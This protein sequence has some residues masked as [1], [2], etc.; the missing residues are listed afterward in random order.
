MCGI[1]GII[2][3]NKRLDATFRKETVAQM[4][5]AIVH[6]GPD[7][8]GFFNN[9]KTSLAMRRLSIIDLHSGD[10]PLWN[11]DKSVLVF[12]N[13]EIYNYLDLKKDLLAKGHRFY[14]NSD[15]ETL[16]HLYEEYGNN[17]SSHLKG[18]FAFCLYDLK[19]DQLLISR[20]RFGEK[21]LYYHWKDQVLSFSSEVASLLENK[22][23]PRLLN[24]EV[25][26]Y[27]LG[28]AFIPEPLTL[29]K[30]VKTLEPGHHMIVSKDKLTIAP[31]FSIDYSQN[32]NRI[33]NTNEAVEYIE[34]FLRQAVSRQSIS[35]VPLGAFLS[36][37]IDSSTVCTLLQEQSSKPIDTFTVKFEEASYDE[38]HIAREVAQRIGS[39]HHE[40]TIP[41]QEFT[42]DIFWEII[43]HVGLP[44]PDSSAIPVYL[45]S[46]EIRKHVK[47]ALSGDGGDEIFAGYP[48][49]GWWKKIAKI[50]KLPRWARKAALSVTNSGLLPLN[51]NR[52]R[53]INRGI[54]ASMKGE[55][56]ISLEIHRMFMDDEM[57]RIFAKKHD[58]IFDQFIKTPTKFKT[59]S[60]LR[61]S[62]YHRIKHNLVTDM[63]IK[64]DR[65]SMANSLE[66]RAPFLDPDLFNASLR[67]SDELLYDGT[68][69]KKI[70]REIMKDK[71]PDSVFNHPKS[72]FSIPLHKYQN[73]VY[74]ALS[75]KLLNKTNPLFK[76]L[77]FAEVQKLSQATFSKQEDNS[78]T[79]IYRSSHQHWTLMMLAGWI[80]R[81]NIELE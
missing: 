27:Y 72:G 33:S 54:T 44:F 67:L 46:K 43:D 32:G 77:N 76:V 17:F 5:A 64:V 31:Y 73:Q 78:K 52:L 53:Q 41:N 62:M 35:D 75:E 68:T 58:F 14:S 80:Q 49:F 59:W 74:Q 19:K 6:R 11:E 23:V 56:G 36:G 79:T 37:G 69:G 25:L 70:I 34:P 18:M 61:K 16:V 24:T 13:G 66:V 9:E 29:L 7:G 38:S 30:E 21:P 71:I 51:Q 50:E 15:T 57:H 60:P 39:N 63:L 47:V 8:A 48:V 81:F 12:M 2:D 3:L 26:D 1:T 28:A 55:E 65:M 42:E 40:I 10:Q 4:N 22:K 20:D 45:I